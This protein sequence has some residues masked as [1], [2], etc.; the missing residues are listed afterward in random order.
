MTARQINTKMARGIVLLLNN[1]ALAAAHD[2]KAS[3]R[4][5]IE[6]LK[7]ARL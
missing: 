5:Q 6:V 1:A 7:R 2:S 4:G 3:P